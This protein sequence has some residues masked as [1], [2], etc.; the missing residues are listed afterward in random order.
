MELKLWECNFPGADP[1]CGE[2]VPSISLY[3]LDSQ[4][5][6]PVIVVYQG[7]GYGARAGHE[8]EPIARWLNSIGV[9]AVICSYRVK[10]YKHPWPSVDARR[11][12]RLVRFNAEKWNIDPARIGVIGFSAGGHLAATVSTIFEDDYTPEVPDDI[13]KISARPDFSVLC[14]PVISFSEYRHSG[15]MRNLLG[16]NPDENLV[17]KY[18]LEKRV[19]AETPPAFI[20]HTA[21]DKSVP[22]EN[23]TLYA[24]ALSKYKIPHEYHIFVD[25][26]HGIGIKEQYPSIVPA[27]KQLFSTWLKVM[28]FVE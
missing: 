10:P 7:G 11:A 3:L 16:E 15:S 21:N 13:D 2:H 18:S 26:P 20:W 9:S 5:I 12:I 6:R 27:W 23:S 25:G 19:T 28:K 22:V 17:Q 14:Y 24:N 1:V 4:I 8:G